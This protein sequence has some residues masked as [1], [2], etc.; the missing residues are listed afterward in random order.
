MPNQPVCV[1][2]TSTVEEAAIIVGWLQER[3]VGATVL[4]PDNPGVMAFG[5]TDPEGIEIFVADVETAERAK[6]LLVEHDQQRT[7]AA[8]TDA[9]GGTLEVT[10][11]SCGQTSMFAAI[12]RGTVQECPECGAYLDVPAGDA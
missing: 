2:R 9:P 10:C 7:T 6:A 11:E 8:A 3:G 4:D 5:V 1:R 12:S